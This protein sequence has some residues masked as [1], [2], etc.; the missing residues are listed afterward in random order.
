MKRRSSLPHLT[1]KNNGKQSISRNNPNIQ[2]D[3]TE[4]QPEFIE[5]RT[6]TDSYQ[7]NTRFKHQNLEKKTKKVF[8]RKTLKVPVIKEGP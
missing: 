7:L 5:I 2:K 3:L 8:E 6:F 4:P 1:I